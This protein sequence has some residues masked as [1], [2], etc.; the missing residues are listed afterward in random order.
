M[1]DKKSFGKY[2][3]E[4]RKQR[5]L[6]QEELANKLYVIPTTISKWERGVTYPDITVITPLCKELKISEH[7]FFT[8]CD[9]EAMNR[10]KKEVQ[11]YR[12]LKKWLFNIINFGYLIGIITCFIC[13]LVINHKLSWFLIVL[14][15]VLISFSITTIPVYLKKNK[16]KFLK[17]SL[18]DTF[19]VYLLLFTINFVNKG[20]WLLESYII[21]SF[22]FSFLWLAI[23]ICTFTKIIIP[24]KISISLITLAIVTVFTNPVCE[25]VLDFSRND[26][27]TPNIICA[28]IMIVVAAVITLKELFK[29][30]N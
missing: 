19:L 28:T 12:T 26:S 22:V 29:N 1:K 3:A 2:V 14:V 8:A 10:E 9:D 13:N 7:E 21:A 23:L 16:Y 4:K 27:N 15:G 30:K 20:T 6:T 17:I 11:K 18:I 25:T 24:Y 5:G